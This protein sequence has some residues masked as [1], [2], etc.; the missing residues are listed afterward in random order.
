MIGR[1]TE[2]SHGEWKRVPAHLAISAHGRH[3][4][5]SGQRIHDDALEPA[6]ATRYV[7]GDLAEVEAAG[8]GHGRHEPRQPQRRTVQSVGQLSSDVESRGREPNQDDDTHTRRCDDGEQGRE[9][10]H[11]LDVHRFQYA[12]TRCE[13]GVLSTFPARY[14]EVTS[15]PFLSI[16]DVDRLLAE[17]T[18]RVVVADVR[19]YL[20]GRDGR[21]IH[22][23]G[24]VPGAVYVDVDHDL[25][26]HGDA[27][28]GRHP[29]PSPEHFAAAMSRLG[30]GDDTWVVAYDDTGGMTA[31]RL[32]VML[33]MVGCRASLLDGGLGAWVERHGDVLETGDVDTTTATFTPRPW[34]NERLAGF[35][36]LDRF[37]AHRDRT[38]TV[39][40]DA[41]APERFRGDVVVAAD[42]RL[43]HVPG[44]Y[45]SPWNSLL[46]DG[47]LKARD[48][49]I[50]HYRSL[51][52]DLADDVIASC[53]SGVSA[54]L[55]V[56]AME[57][58]GFAPPR[59]FVASWSG[60][61]SD[62]DRPAEIGP[63]APDR[64]RFVRARRFDV[65]RDAPIGEGAL[66]DLRRARR[67]KRLAE[68]EWFEA[69][70]RV[71]LAA[72]VF[73]GSFLFLSGLVT[74]GTMDPD[75]TSRVITEGPGWLGV[76]ALVAAAIGLR[77]GSL[78]GPLALEDAD[79]RHVL[80]APIDRR[81]VLLGP[82]TQR[83][84]TFAFAGGLVGA[85]AG[86]LSGHR[87]P[88]SELTWALSGALFGA[89]VAVLHIA[90]ALVA[91]SLRFPRW[92]STLVG[93]ILVLTQV[94][95]AMPDRVDTVGPGDTFGGLAFWEIRVEWID[96]LAPVVSLALLAIGL[97][98]LR[99]ISVDAL[100][101]RASLVSQLR[102]AVTLQDLRTVM[103][104]RR[105]LSHER[106][107]SRPWITRRRGGGVSA[108]WQRAWHGILRFP[109]AR[110]VR[111]AV[112]AVIAGAASGG[113][114]NGTAPLAAIAGFACF[115]IGLELTEPLAQEIDHGDLTDRLPSARGGVYLR[116]LT[117]PAAASIPFAAI[118]A[119]ALGVVS[120]DS[121]SVAAI[122]GL[123]ATLAGLAGA[124]VNVVTGAPDPITTVSRDATLPPEI[125]G[126]A[127][128]VKAIWPIALATAGQV[129]VL[130]A[131]SARRSGSGAEAAASRGAVFALLVIGVVAAW[132]HRR[133]DIRAWFDRARQESTSRQRGVNS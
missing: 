91:H 129:P 98:L 46:V 110:I 87:L 35:E 126:T 39:V 65:R 80:S 86:Q 66:R 131:E 119:V 56:L 43:G 99:R 93:S 120:G 79:V 25:A 17:P 82:A 55:N 106:S 24:H 73:G 107:R 29:L 50:E 26:S 40:L 77:S 12:V 7:I 121:W 20:D 59:L 57:H 11:R 14:A 113:V 32:V 71:Y 97:G 76:I 127:N 45:N 102:F 118:M 8:R 122:V 19:W 16:D 108:E 112:L 81:R 109:G 78:G 74:D 27:I 23:S 132:I 33:R 58:A 100:S 67:R 103:L 42:P 130:V 18:I 75:T 133:D 70:Y 5:N 54:C 72:F 111:T 92:T 123:P 95:T 2:T 62:P 10:F 44:A 96:V 94:V 104:L 64:S 117:A 41:R 1:D 31:G 30:I 49:L 13:D 61:A 36:D 51:C 85:A 89:T 60:W 3:E 34:P 116:L 22:R 125:A 37:V 69:L 128:V 84:R 101:R 4:Q 48:E 28:G 53:G 83:A 63:S 90:C 124:A 68:L 38:S 21:A 105:Q 114:M 9:E 88:G 52:V 115:V 6:E 47:H 15:P